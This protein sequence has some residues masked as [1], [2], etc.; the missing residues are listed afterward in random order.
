[1]KMTI[2]TC[3]AVAMVGLAPGQ[4]Y[5]AEEDKILDMAQAFVAAFDAGNAR[6]IASQFA[7]DGEFVDEDGQVFRGRQ[8]I[9]KEFAAFFAEMK[10][11]RLNLDIESIRLIGAD[12]AVEEGTATSRLPGNLPA[13]TSRYLAVHV[14]RNGAWKIASNRSLASK[15]ASP[16]EQLKQL[17][18]LLGEWVDES[19]DAVVK[20]HCKWSED[21][22]FLLIDFEAQIRGARTMKGSQRIG[23]DPLT[24]QI[25]SWVFDSEGGH[26]EGY[27]GRMGD[28]WVIKVSGVRP[29]G[30]AATATNTY[31]PTGRDRIQWT[32]VD[33]I[34][35]GEG[36]PDLRVT[37]VRTPPQPGRR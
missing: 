18:W 15:P 21:G 37:I 22:N 31:A 8:A 35:G 32:S 24:R 28:R 5:C 12:L 10:D 33:R 26:A 20:H 36:E 6:A 11:A 1:M 14:K 25:K 4:V 27:W 19:D 16:H 3:A 2:L 23:W 17:Q 34:I 29:D 7:E 13:T 9:E 30:V